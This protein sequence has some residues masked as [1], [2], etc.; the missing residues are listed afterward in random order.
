MSKL[1][2]GL[3]GITRNVVSHATLWVNGA[4]L[5]FSRSTGFSTVAE[6]RCEGARLAFQPLGRYAPIPEPEPTSR[7]QAALQP[8]PGVL[9][10]NQ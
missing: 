6:D 9:L 10:A 4:Y 7:L 1:W 3:L 2:I 5:S 8:P